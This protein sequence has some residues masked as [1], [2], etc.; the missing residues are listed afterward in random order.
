MLI[1]SV[2][3]NGSDLEKE[4]MDV[5]S[6]FQYFIKLNT[7][8]KQNNYKTNKPKDAL[9]PPIIEFYSQNTASKALASKTESRAQ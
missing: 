9:Q 2:A 7:A 8:I 1:D 5:Y 6:A 4:G 3:I